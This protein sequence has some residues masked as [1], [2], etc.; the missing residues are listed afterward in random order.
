MQDDAGP[1][2]G[3]L[4]AKERGIPRL[5][6]AEMQ[7]DPHGTLRRY[8]AAH[9][10]AAHE[11]GS[12]FV[13]RHADVDRLIRDPRAAQSTGTALPRLMGVKEGVLFDTFDHGML[14]SNGE[15]HRRRRAPFTRILAARAMAELRPAVRQAAERLI[16]GWHGRGE[17]EFMAGFA[18]PMPALIIS[19]LLGLPEEDIPAT[20]RHVYEAT[21]FVSLSVRPDEIPVAAAAMQELKDYVAALLEDRRRNPRG[22][23]L[24]GYLA[25][26]EEAGDLTAEE[27]LFQ[28]VQLIIA[29]TDTTRVAAAM[30]VGLLLQ[31][32]EQWD[33]V[34]RDPGL[35]PAAVAETLRFEP[36]VAA[37]SR[38]AA[39]EIE[40]DGAVIPAG[41]FI[42]LSTMSAMRDE[43]AYAD[44]DRFDIARQ[45]HPRL[46]PV[47]GGGPHR[48]IGEALARIELEEGLAALAA[49]IPDLQLE[50]APAIQGYTGIRRVERMQLSWKV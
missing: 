30:A 2:S 24:S 43:R 17:V 6:D 14:T 10:L 18:T 39:T 40:L 41:T 49:R 32:R 44:P 33:A 36:S 3:A 35:V 29:G 8:R 48:C 15:V 7:G 9:P 46:H 26:T 50:E 13:L 27:I 11:A 34:C 37:M 4:A 28:I 45:D 25:A 12:V 23:F 31:H 19:G 38:I 16:D 21:R 47:F 20:T 42:S 5:T 1:A 22:D